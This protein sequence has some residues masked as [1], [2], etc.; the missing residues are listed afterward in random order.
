MEQKDLR[1]TI[2][3]EML[4]WVEKLASLNKTKNFTDHFP[5]LEKWKTG[6]KQPS[7][8]D[9]AEMAEVANL[10]EGYLYL[11]A[12]FKYDLEITD[13]RS[14]DRELQ[15]SP[16]LMNI[17][18]GMQRKQNFLEDYGLDEDFR[19]VGSA[20]INQHPPM[21]AEKMRETFG[22]SWRT[23]ASSWWEAVVNLR[24]KLEDME[25]Y[26]IFGSYSKDRVEHPFNPDEFAC[27]IH[28]NREMGERTAPVVFLNANN[29][30]EMMMFTLA[31]AAAHVFLGSEG[32]G[33]LDDP[34]DMLTDKNTSH[35][36]A[37]FC[38]EVAS[39]FL[40]TTQELDQALAL[41]G[42]QSRETSHDSEGIDS[43]DVQSVTAQLATYL[44]VPPCV[45]AR[46][47]YDAWTIDIAEFHETCQQL[48]DRATTGAALMDTNFYKNLDL[49][50]GKNFASR[51]SH[52][53][54]S[55]I[56]FRD[57]YNLTG[58]IIHRDYEK[59]TEYAKDR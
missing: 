59:Y 14:G 11:G 58:L 15:P 39:C 5:D 3:R 56:N 12:P 36:T 44:S 28:T 1:V 24:Q 54:G 43:A 50:V 6:E 9:I 51:V 49:T 29:A 31:R 8:V 32:T 10:G 19:F 16:N 21:V 57:A 41:M 2:S 46:K 7:V 47:L 18:Y 13:F 52:S 4:E 40:V 55:I 25:V 48:S 53:A 45:A 35:K 22:I 26:T 37:K 23:E 17:V 34:I 33:L 20:N 27:V 30:A 38:A 42:L